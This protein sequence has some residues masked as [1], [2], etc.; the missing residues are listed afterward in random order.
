MPPLSAANSPPS[1]SASGRNGRTV[2]S[3]SAALDVDGERHELAG[4]GQPD[5]LGDR[6]ARLVLRFARCWRRGAG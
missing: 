1:R 5:L 2:S 4:E 6:V 3:A